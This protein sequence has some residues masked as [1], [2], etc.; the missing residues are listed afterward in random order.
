MSFFIYA[1]STTLDSVGRV[2]DFSVIKEKV[3]GWIDK[4]WDHTIIAYVKDER[5]WKNHNEDPAN[6]KPA[7]ILPCNPTSENIA[8]YLLRDVCPKLME[9][10]GVEVFRVQVWETEN[11]FAEVSLD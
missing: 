10:T 6:N 9:G 8:N 1:R 2:I 11:C 4:H 5:Y 7:Y 3:G